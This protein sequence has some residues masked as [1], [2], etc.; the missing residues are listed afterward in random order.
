M[1][2]NNYQLSS[3]PTNPRKELREL[4]RS[5][6]KALLE[7][8]FQGAKAIV[9]PVQFADI[10]EVIYTLGGVQS[11]GDNYFQTD[12]ITVARKMV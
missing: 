9:Q 7:R 1:T 8:D 10:A 4:V 12:L 5:Q 6:L 3:L 11:G 2:E